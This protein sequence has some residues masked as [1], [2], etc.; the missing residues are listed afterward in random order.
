MAPC[1]EGSCVAS[2]AHARLVWKPSSGGDTNSR[3]NAHERIVKAAASGRQSGVHERFIEV[4]AGVQAA[5]LASIP[6][7]SATQ[8]R[9]VL[10]GRMDHEGRANL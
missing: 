8:D 10:R 2:P 4:P 3:L 7:R 6:W 9:R 1:E 5:A